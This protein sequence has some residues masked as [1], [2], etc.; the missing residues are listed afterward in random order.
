MK[1]NDKH[2]NQI[3]NWITFIVPIQLYLNIKCVFKM[4]K[5]KYNIK[6]VT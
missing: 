1:M 2:C 4:F 5:I 6:D 3:V